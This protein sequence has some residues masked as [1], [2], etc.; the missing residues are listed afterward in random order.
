MAGCPGPHEARGLCQ[1]HYLRYYMRG[2]TELTEPQRAMSIEDRFRAKVHSEPCA[3]G[4]CDG[5]LRWRAGKTGQGYGS[6]YV[7]GSRVLAHR[8][9]YELDVGPIPPLHQVDHVRE[10]GCRH[11]DCVKKEHLEPVSLEENVRRAQ[12]GLRIN[13][14]KWQTAFFAKHA[15][16]RFWAKV[17]RT[18]G[19]DAHWPWQAFLDQDGHA[20]TS[21]QGRTH[22]AREVAWILANGAVPDG[23]VPRQS[24]GQN[25][26]V[27]PAHLVLVDRKA[28]RERRAAAARAGKRRRSQGLAPG[29]VPVTGPAPSVPGGQLRPRLGSAPG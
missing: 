9:A 5:C 17:D 13:N 8:F 24:C 18:G 6:F 16:E 11:R 29:E 23:K 3:C 20:K 12:V 26:C 15:A 10:R 27:N 2:T 19:P 22:M 4:E 14:G 21:W 25:D 1:K 28:D 7:N